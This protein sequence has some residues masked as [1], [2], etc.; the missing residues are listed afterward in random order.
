MLGIDARLPIVS[1]LVA[2]LWDHL[3]TLDEEIRVIWTCRGR[4]GYLAKLLF[5]LNRYG[6]EI[7]LLF[8]A[9]GPNIIHLPMSVGLPSCL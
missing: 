6:S 2:L 1:G 3:L 5:A 7:I 4:S 9:Y 8:I